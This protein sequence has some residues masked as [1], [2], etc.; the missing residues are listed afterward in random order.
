MTMPSDPAIEAYLDRLDRALEPMPASGRAEI[1]SEIKSHLLDA[2]RK[3][4]R[5]SMQSIL[6]SFGDPKQVAERYL[7]ERGLSSED[8][9]RSPK[10]WVLTAVLSRYLGLIG[11][12]RFYTGRIGLGILKLVT[13]GGFTLWYLIDMILLDLGR[14][15]D[16]DGKFVQPERE[17]KWGTRVLLSIFLG[18]A[19]ADR[20]YLG[21][22]VLAVLKLLSLGGFGIWWFIDVLLALSADRKNAR[23]THESSV[24]KWVFGGL[25]FVALIFFICLGA[26]IWHFSPLIQI[27]NQ[28]VRLFNG[29]IDI[30]GDT[31]DVKVGDSVVGGGEARSFEGTQVLAAGA[32]DSVSLHFVNGKAKV[33]PSPDNKIH[34]KFEV[35]GGENSS[36]SL[37][38]REFKVDLSET[39]SANGELQVPGKVKIRVEGVNG[40]LSVERPRANVEIS[41]VN[42]NVSFVPDKNL[43]YRY[44]ANTVHGAQSNLESSASK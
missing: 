37:S 15:R 28:R 11:A 40:D 39:G 10:D 4:P 30:N 32:V 8:P 33:S 27:N 5:R 20:A 17:K 41:M 14:M 13:F 22:G 34:W 42:G 24:V 38:G 31:G 44:D 36:A 29:A 35:K 16:T 9:N 26:L 3:S 7:A 12:D 6:D 23:E 2:K 19:G 1:V 43:K 18:F 21:Q 25:A